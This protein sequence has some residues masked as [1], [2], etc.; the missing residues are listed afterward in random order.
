[1]KDKLSRVER[2]RLV[3]INLF[4]LCIYDFPNVLTK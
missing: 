1:M 4:I 2:M 3:L